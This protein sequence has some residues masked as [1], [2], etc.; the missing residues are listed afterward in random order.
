MYLIPILLV[1]TLMLRLTL[2]ILLAFSWDSGG[3]L[4]LN[5]VEPLFG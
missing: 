5:C 2:I 4:A 1:F 3:N